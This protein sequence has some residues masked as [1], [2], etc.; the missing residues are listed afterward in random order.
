LL[1]IFQLFWEFFV[2]RADDALLQYFLSAASCFP[3]DHLEF[4]EVMKA[5]TRIFECLM[6]DEGNE[7]SE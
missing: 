3:L 7:K 1:E 5:V 6:K 4:I 2:P